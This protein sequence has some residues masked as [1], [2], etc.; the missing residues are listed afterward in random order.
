MPVT[1]IQG[2]DATFSTN[3]AS[4]F[5]RTSF[6]RCSAKLQRQLENFKGFPELHMR[7]VIEQ[8]PDPAVEETTSKIRRNASKIRTV[9]IEQHEVLERYDVASPRTSH[10]SRSDADPS[11]LS[12]NSFASRL[13]ASAA[14]AD[15]G[16]EST[17]ANPAHAIVDAESAS[18]IRVADMRSLVCEDT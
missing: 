15:N 17:I 16:I 18:R 1:V 6:R 13:G 11:Q 10:T 5:G 7:I 9:C 2:L 8:Y 14:D 12:S 3:A 4:S